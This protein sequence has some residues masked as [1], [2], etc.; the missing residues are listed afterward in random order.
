ML[1]KCTFA[2]HWFGYHNCWFS[3]RTSVRVYKMLN[4]GLL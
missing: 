2:V 1:S 3:I 4:A